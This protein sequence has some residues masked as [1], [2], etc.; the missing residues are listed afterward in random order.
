MDDLTTERSF[1]SQATCVMHVLG[2]SFD[3]FSTSFNNKALVDVRL[4][5]AEIKCRY[6]SANLNNIDARGDISVSLFC[7]VVLVYDQMQFWGY[8]HALVQYV[9]CFIVNIMVI[10]GILSR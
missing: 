10:Y 2:L 3:M 1:D 9:T 5:G 7:F 6:C 4:T 8:F